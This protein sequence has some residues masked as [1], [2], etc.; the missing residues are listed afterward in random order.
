MR[1]WEK[2]NRSGS[3]YGF[4]RWHDENGFAIIG[5]SASVDELGAFECFF[6]HANASK[7]CLWIFVETTVKEW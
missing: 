4:T 3:V 2:R 6:L 5:I 7:G 1:L